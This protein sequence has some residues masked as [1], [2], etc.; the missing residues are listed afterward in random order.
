MINLVNYELYEDARYLSVYN[1]YQRYFGSANKHT[2][3]IDIMNFFV[4]MGNEIERLT[5]DDHSKKTGQYYTN[6]LAVVDLILDNTINFE[7]KDILTKKILEPSCGYGIFIL[8]IIQR[9]FDQNYSNE[10]LVKFINNNIVG[11]DIS[12]TMIYFTELN[13]KLL[14]VNLYGDQVLFERVVPKIYLSDT[15]HKPEAKIIS[16]SL[17]EEDIEFIE[18]EQAKKIKLNAYNG[19]EQFDVVIG[20]PPYVTFYGR[21]DK[22]KT[23]SLRR[24]YIDNYKFIPKSVKNGKFNLLMFFLEQALDWTKENG[25]ITFIL[26][27]SFFETAYGFIRKYLLENSKIV[28][29]ITDITAFNVASGQIILCLKKSSNLNGNQNNIVN[30]IKYGENLAIQQIQQ[31]EWHN[32]LNEYKFSIINKES[33]KIAKKINLLSTTVGNIFKG[34]SLRTCCMLLDMEDKFVSKNVS[35]GALP[36]LEGSKSL[37]EKYGE[38]SNKKWFTYDKDLQDKINDQLQIQLAKEGIKNKKRIGLGNLNVYNSP[39]LFIR[40]SSKRIISTL[41]LFPAAANNSLYCLSE[42]RN[43][44]EGIDRLK[45]TLAQFNSDLITFYA[46]VKRIIRVS[47]GKQPQIKVSDLKEIPLITDNKILKELVYLVD[48][49]YSFPEKKEGKIKQINS[50]IY[51][52]YQISDDE[53]VY[54]N[55][56]LSSF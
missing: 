15:T 3:S 7:K 47:S 46:L 4:V 16:L 21:R 48:E 11:F 40:Q 24:Y 42:E 39:K 44:K 29:L 33:E 31:K 35:P 45:S 34:K 26:D 19:V 27:V 38:L 28:K 20:N 50:L 10:E 30:V 41:C 18:S 2:D 8:R 14:M 36:Y 51:S 17:F 43:D 52:Y 55:D 6:D 49:I 13:I 37:N 54:I 22:K 5:N 9:L 12:K 53:I 32:P 23:E 25:N 1:Q 56:Y